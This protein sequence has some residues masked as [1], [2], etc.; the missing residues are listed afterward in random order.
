[1]IPPTDEKHDTSDDDDDMTSITMVTIIE[2][3]SSGFHVATGAFR[4]NMVQLPKDTTVIP[5]HY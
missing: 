2:Q 3:G 4:V 5:L 1:M